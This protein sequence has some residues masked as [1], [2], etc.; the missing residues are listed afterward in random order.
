ML[1]IFVEDV[2]DLIGTVDYNLACGEGGRQPL[3]QRTLT[4]NNIPPEVMEAW[5]GPQVRDVSGDQADGS[6]Q[7]SFRTGVSVF[8]FEEAPLYGSTPPGSKR[9]K[10]S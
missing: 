10:T 7:E 5:L 6:S 9:E 1:Q 8:C 4:Y 3:F 2:L